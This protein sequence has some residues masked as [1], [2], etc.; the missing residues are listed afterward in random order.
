MGYEKKLKRAVCLV[1]MLRTALTH[2]KTRKGSAHDEN[3][4]LNLVEAVMSGGRTETGRN[5]RVIADSGAAMH[6]SLTEGTI[7]L[8][9]TKK[10]AWKACLRELLWFISGSTDADQLAKS[11]CHIWDGNGTREFLD[12]RGLVGNRVGDL[13]PVY[14]HQWRH[15]N[16]PYQGAD[17][18]YAGK[19][20]DQLQKVID[21]LSDPV[22]RTSRRILMCAWNP[23][24]QPEMALPP[25]H[26]LAQFHV[27]AGV[28]LSCSLYQRSGD[29]GLGVP[30][31]VA[32][33]AT[34]THLLAM[35]CG[36]EAHELVH[37]LGHC[38]VYEE[39]VEGLGEQISRFPMS[40]PSLRIAAKRERIEDYE[41]SD[42]VVQEYRCHPKIV[43]PFCA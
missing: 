38:H 29:L 33:Y 42:F 27:A 1:Q 35:H 2:L 28:K 30:F 19:G 8:F 18:D 11:G 9:T 26:V 16:A 39:H 17:A 13:G 20:V 5:G 21:A 7:P 32:S 4:Y 34:L 24:Q 25:C 36:L 40:F 15:F 43:L 14:G 37:H 41:E 23:A 12:S 31:N 6:F 10:V 22:Q 3:Q